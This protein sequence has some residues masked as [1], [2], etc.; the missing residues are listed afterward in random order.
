MRFFSAAGLLLCLLMTKSSFSCSSIPNKI[1]LGD[2]K[3]LWLKKEILRENDSCV[4]FVSKIIMI[5]HSDTMTLATF[6][7][8]RLKTGYLNRQVFWPEYISQRYFIKMKKLPDENPE[9]R[10]KTI[11]TKPSERQCSC[12]NGMKF[13]RNIEYYYLI[14]NKLNKREPE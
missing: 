4:N 2:H 14:D 11:R 1:H 6:S 12:D 7:G 8:Y 10:V 5:Q 3:I 9:I 13:T